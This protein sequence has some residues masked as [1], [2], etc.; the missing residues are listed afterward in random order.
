MNELGDDVP[1]DKQHTR[2]DHNLYRMLSDANTK[3]ADAELSL[4]PVHRGFNVF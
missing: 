3:E 4:R 1:S 2:R